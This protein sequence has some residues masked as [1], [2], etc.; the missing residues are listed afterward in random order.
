MLRS[1]LVPLDGSQM[2][3]WSLPL[4]TRVARSTGAELHLAH[5]HVPYEPDHLLSNSSFQWEGVDMW[6]YDRRHLG[7][8]DQYLHGWEERLQGEGTT[9][10]VK[11][12]DHGTP[13]TDGLV[14]YSDEVG[15]DLIVMTSHGRSGLQRALWGSVADEMIRRTPVPVLVVHPDREDVPSAMVRAVDHILVP[16]DGS[17]LAEGVLG[18]AK[19]LAE[20][21]GA[22]ITLTH[23]VPDLS[24]LGPR[25]LGFRPDRLEPALDG[26]LAYLEPLAADLR[27]EGLDAT[28]HP[29]SG[30]EP[31]KSIA[32]LA[33]ELGVDLVALA[34]HGYGGVKR[35]MLGSVTD[36]LL[37]ATELPLLVVRPREEKPTVIL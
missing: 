7:Q 33:D 24:Y 29:V 8:E 31:A 10:D 37:A 6:D 18:P 23:V 20:A 35:T 9:V 16:L 30:G 17:P 5:V 1:L 11:V 12:L 13:V 21:M 34:T 26:A 14:A 28:V 15:A 22:R 36:R 2:G 27:R 25:I 4:A 32:A 3:E 19:D